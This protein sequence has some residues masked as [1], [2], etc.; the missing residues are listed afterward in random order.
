MEQLGTLLHLSF[1]SIAVWPDFSKGQWEALVKQ[2]CTTVTQVRLCS[3]SGSCFMVTEFITISLYTII[4][5]SLQLL[6]AT[7][8]DISGQPPLFWFL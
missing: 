1:S 6:N 2:C 5:L 8:M 4:P 3:A 7:L